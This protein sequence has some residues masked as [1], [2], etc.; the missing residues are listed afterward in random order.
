MGMDAQLLAI[1]PYEEELVQYL[2]HDPWAYKDVKPGERVVATV[3]ACRT[4]EASWGLATALGFGP[5]ELGKHVME[6]LTREQHR[7]LMRFM[8]VGEGKVAADCW[9]E[10]LDALI[11]RG[12]WM[13]V[14]MPCG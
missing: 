3:I 13:F 14:Y 6:G 7:A 10:A 9:V 11:S 4:S 8:L 1:G 5:M 2:D 12:T